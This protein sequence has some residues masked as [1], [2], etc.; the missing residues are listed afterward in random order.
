MFMRGIGQLTARELEEIKRRQASRDYS[1]RP[2]LGPRKRSDRAVV[3]Q[4][5]QQLLRSLR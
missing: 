4:L 5:R 3:E 2:R 1:V